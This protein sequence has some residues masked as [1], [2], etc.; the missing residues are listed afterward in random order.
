LLDLNSRVEPKED[1]KKRTYNRRKDPVQS[2]TLLV[3]FVAS[4]AD[5][6]KTAKVKRKREETKADNQCYVR[7]QTERIR[8]LS[9]KRT[10][11]GRRPKTA[12]TSIVRP[13]TVLP[14]YD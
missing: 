9:Q 13:R 3:A 8:K 2:N 7:L 6:Q 1:T 14:E 4:Q 10:P 11:R 12:K 5:T